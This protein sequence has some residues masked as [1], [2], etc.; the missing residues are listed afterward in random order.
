LPVKY[1]SSSH[2]PV[3]LSFPMRS[4]LF[5]LLLLGCASPAVAQDLFSSQPPE[6][7]WVAVKPKGAAPP[8]FEPDDKLRLF[9]VTLLVG[10]PDGIAPALSFHPWTNWVHIDFGP[11]ALMSFGFRGG[12]TFDPLDWIVAPTL[13]LSAGYNGW[14]DAPFVSGSAIRFTT[15]YMNVQAGIEV[16][17]RSRF[18]L[19]LRGGYSHLWIDTDYYPSYSGRQATS[20]TTVR[21]GVFPSL[22]LGLTGYL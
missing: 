12:V 13:T 3:A 16:G 6:G 1:T 9:G 22:N 10:L 7:R 18:R 14:A 5:T 21:V 20:S 8:L 4:L 11:S 19:F 2:V 17:R 15:T